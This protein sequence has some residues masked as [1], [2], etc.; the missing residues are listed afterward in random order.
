V[1]GK[2]AHLSAIF[3]KLGVRDRLHLALF[4]RSTGAV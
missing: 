2:N 3:Q 1:R 4:M